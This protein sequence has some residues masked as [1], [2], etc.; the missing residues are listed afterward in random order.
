MCRIWDIKL[1]R[2]ISNKVRTSKTLKYPIKI[3]IKKHFAKII[4]LKEAFRT[5]NSDFTVK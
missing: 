5:K 1:N 3:R 4:K 2:K